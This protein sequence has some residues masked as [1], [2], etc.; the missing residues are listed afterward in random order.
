M[1]RPADL[2]VLA[3]VSMMCVVAT[4]GGAQSSGDVKGKESRFTV[5]PYTEVV[6]GST[7]YTLLASGVKSRLEFPLNMLVLGLSSTYALRSGESEEWRFHLSA[8]TAVSGPWGVLKD[9]DWYLVEDAPPIKFSYT[10]SDAEMFF[11]EVE[12]AVEKRLLSARDADL[13]GSLG[14]AFQYISQD[15]LGYSG[16]Q[17]VLVSSGDADNP[18]TFELLTDSYNG[19]A[20]EYTIAYHRLAAGG[21]LRWRPY[22]SFELEL[23]LLPQ[24]MYVSDRDDHVLRN[25]LSTA[26]GFGGGL[27]G[28][29][30]LSYRWQGNPEYQSYVSLNGGL[31][32]LR[33]VTEQSQ[34]WY[35]DDPGTSGNDTGQKYTGLT[36]VIQ[37]LQG[38]FGVSAGVWYR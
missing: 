19:I 7:E 32:Y 16:W 15:A 13:F 9:H 29:V 35:G 26:A 21:V 30:S 12:A 3:F 1:N 5:A 37:T 18:P 8:G 25:K 34:E 2:K 31:L 10:E 23:S 4:I 17:Y 28:C 6:L 24:L 36:H 20:L 38:S 33:A 27:A 22:R 14:Y 11:F